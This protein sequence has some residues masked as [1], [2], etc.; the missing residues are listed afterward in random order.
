[1]TKLLDVNWYN[2]HNLVRRILFIQIAGLLTRFKYYA[3]WSISEG[4]CIISG[5][6]FNGYTSQGRTRWDRV[7]NIDVLS[8]E[9][10]QNVK[11]L[12]D[13]WNMN[14]NVWLRSCVYR[15]V[16]PKNQKPGFKSTLITFITSAFW[17]GL[18]SG[19]YLTFVYGGFLQ[20]LGRIIRKCVR[21]LFLVN[22]PSDRLQIRKKNLYDFCS[23]LT[24]QILI[25]FAVIPFLILDFKQSLVAWTSVY[26][27]GLVIVGFSFVYFKF[28]GG[29]KHFSKKVENLNRKIEIEKIEDED[30]FEGQPTAEQR[31]KAGLDE[32]LLTRDVD[33]LIKNLTDGTINSQEVINEI[34]SK[35]KNGTEVTKDVLKEVIDNKNQ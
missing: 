9:L 2:R 5:L 23:V 13:A 31:E 19:Y 29:V 3:V 27:Y 12:L 16:T 7:R 25:N 8:V 32:E 28:L 18:N 30:W 1:M 11:E 26:N 21:P 15:R 4:S 35:S 17:H 14:T 24:V 10:A 34:K 33:E 6:G 20:N 22:K